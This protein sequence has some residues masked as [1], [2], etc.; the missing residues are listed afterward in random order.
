M[1]DAPRES[2]IPRKSPGSNRSKRTRKVALGVFGYVS[3]ITFIGALI[4][5]AGMFF[6]S[7]QISGTLE[8]REQELAAV[9][10]SFAQEN[11]EMVREYETYL[12]T[13]DRTFA[14]TFSMEDLFGSLENSVVQSAFLSSL[15]LEQ[16]M[17]NDSSELTLSAEVI[18]NSFD[19]ALFQRD[20]YREFPLLE[21]F[22]LNDVVLVESGQ[23]LAAFAEGDEDGPLSEAAL[24]QIAQ[25]TAAGSGV[26]T[27]SIEMTLDR[28]DLPYPP[29]GTAAPE[30]VTPSSTSTDPAPS[31]GGTEAGA[32]TDSVEPPDAASEA[33]AETSSEA[34]PADAPEEDAAIDD[35]AEPAAMPEDEDGFVDEPVNG[36]EQ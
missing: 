18:T 30:P 20:L 14:E 21:R 11:M 23:E 24:S 3:Y 35:A 26:V 31:S 25:A 33:P 19:S 15:E 32:E 22:V 36:E 7:F 5:S 6:I 2:F 29:D 16:E 10:E 13:V 1:P 12:N 28:N 8:E 9:K 27:L 4:L 34:L 17:L